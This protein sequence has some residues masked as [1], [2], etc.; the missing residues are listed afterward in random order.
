MPGDVRAVV[1]R[2]YWTGRASRLGCDFIVGPHV[3]HGRCGADTADKS[4]LADID[5]S[6]TVVQSD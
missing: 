3:R 6:P 4:S 1:R 2:G 5:V